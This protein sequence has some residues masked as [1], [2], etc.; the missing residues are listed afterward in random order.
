MFCVGGIP[1]VAFWPD[2]PDEPNI[3]T[4]LAG[5]READEDEAWR[6]YRRMETDNGDQP[7]T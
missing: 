2:E 3:D 6:E 1:I 7:C 4:A 5:L